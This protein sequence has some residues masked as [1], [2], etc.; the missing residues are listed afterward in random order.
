MTDQTRKQIIKSIVY[1]MTVEEIS[2]IY[3]ISVDE[4]GKIMQD[5]ADD[6]NAER[7]YR[8]MLEGKTC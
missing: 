6:I 1:G 5:N 2:E 8:A 7:E 3:G 4:V